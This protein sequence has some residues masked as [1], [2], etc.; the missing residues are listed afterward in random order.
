MFLIL[1]CWV[2]GDLYRLRKTIYGSKHAAY[3]C[4]TNVRKLLVDID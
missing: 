1:Y 2:E 3:V 4:F